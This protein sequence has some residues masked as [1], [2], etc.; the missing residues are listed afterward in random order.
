MER[1][2]VIVRFADGRILRGYLEKFVATDETVSIDDDSSGRQSISLSDLKAIFYVKTFEGDK[3]YSDRKS[4]VHATARGKKV[5][6]RFFDGESMMGHIEGDVP[7][8]KGFF[9]EQKKGGFFL[10]PVDNQ[11]NNIKVFVVASAVQDVTCF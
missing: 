6:V 7:W 4:F 1:Q 10:I 5:F 3:A 11:S 2:K 8:E 9:L